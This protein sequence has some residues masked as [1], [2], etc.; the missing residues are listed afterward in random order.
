MNWYSLFYWISVADGVKGFFNATSNAFTFFTI[1]LLI[2]YVIS[3]GFL[4]AAQNSKDENDKNIVPSIQVW[5]NG[6][7]PLLITSLII[8]LVTWSLYVFIPSKKDCL[9]IIAGGAVGN[10]IT[11]DST[12]KAIPHDVMVLLSSKIKEE[13]ANTN[14]KKEFLDKKDTLQDMTKEQLIKKLKEV[15]K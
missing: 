15:S 7:K 13:I 10:F 3:R 11:R 12:T 9:I 14:L 5:V 1:L 6:S 2:I 8:C 4:I